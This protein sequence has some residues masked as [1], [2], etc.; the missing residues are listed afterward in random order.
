MKG[1]YFIT[2]LDRSGN[3]SVPS[4]TLV[5]NNCPQYVLPNVF[6]PNEDGKNDTFS[7]FFSDGSITDFD[8]SK[9]PRF[10]RSVDISV[11]DRTG[12]EVFN[13]NSN[14]DNI[15][16]I[17]INWDGKNK[18]GL[19]LAEGT[20]YYNAKVVFD[21]LDGYESEKEIKGWVQLIR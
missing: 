7:P 14:E 2:A 13:Y 1:Y 8:Y 17:Y 3:E 15:N 20:Y 18:F 9:C 19:D 12:N 21:V 5:R 6:T 4:D 10:V 11:V 16:G